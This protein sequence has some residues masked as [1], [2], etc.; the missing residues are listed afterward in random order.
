MF[1]RC[2]GLQAMGEHEV[3]AWRRTAATSSNS[4]AC[5]I[6]LGPVPGEARSR[7]PGGRSQ[8]GCPPSS[9]DSHAEAAWAALDVGLSRLGLSAI[10]SMTAVLKPP[11]QAVMRRLGMVRYRLFDHPRIEMGHALRPHV[12]YVIGQ[13][14]ASS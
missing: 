2:H 7:R 4:A 11:S 3:S 8:F 10:W 13:L 12:V 9:C 1:Q 14:P 6:A 5:F